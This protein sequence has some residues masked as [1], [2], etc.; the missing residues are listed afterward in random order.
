MSLDRNAVPQSVTSLLE[1]AD[2]G[3]LGLPEFQRKFIWQPMRVADL[4]RTIAR[5]WPCGTFLLQRGPQPYACKALEGARGLVR[6]PSLLILDGQQ[7]MT[8]LYHALRERGPEVYFLKIRELMGCN[9]LEDDHISYKSKLKYQASYPDLESEARAGIV[10]IST[11]SKDEEFFRWTN[12]LPRSER[13]TAIMLRSERLAGF[14]HYSI[15]C[16]VLPDDLPLAA[17]A[18]IFETINRTGVRLDAFDLMVA[19]MYPHE[20][21]LRD[22]WEEVCAANPDTIA[23]YRV[24]GLDLLKSIALREHLRQAASSEKVRVKGVRESDVIQLEPDAVKQAWPGAVRGF[25]AAIE[26]LRDCCG[27]IAPDLLP[28]STLLLP[29]VEILRSGAP[30]GEREFGLSLERW[31]WASCFRQTYGQGAN[32]QAVSDARQL[33]TWMQSASRTASVVADFQGMPRDDFLDSRR[34]NKMLLKGL[35]CALLITGARDWSTGELLRDART[36][37]LL[38]PVFPAA[39]LEDIGLRVTTPVVNFSPLLASTSRAIRKE[40]PD[41]VVARPDISQDAMR[42]HLMPTAPVAE[43]DWPEFRDRR[44]RLL[45]ELACELVTGQQGATERQRRGRRLN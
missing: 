18:K 9:D 26:F 40:A 29:L 23:L 34:R 19:K 39:H 14:K 8:A 6:T 15:P 1:A 43:A 28:S 4:L 37:V 17:V 25:V 38:H 12:F 32:T 33:R 36:P 2:E 11:L 35:C 7:R 22:E 13:H 30:A 5:D 31:F 21:K 3:K 27:V 24:E 44:V 10:R 20:F 16:V 42:S 41:L 45:C